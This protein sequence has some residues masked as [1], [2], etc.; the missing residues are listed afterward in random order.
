[1]FLNK[2]LLYVSGLPRNDVK[3]S[4]MAILPHH[5]ASESSL[6]TTTRPPPQAS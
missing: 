1:M 4:S 2:G 6:V 5:T 3:R